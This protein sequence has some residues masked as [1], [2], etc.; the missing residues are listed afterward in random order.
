M[1][2]RWVDRY[3]WGAAAMSFG[4]VTKSFIWNINNCSV[5]RTN[6]QLLPPY[7]IR[8]VIVAVKAVHLNVLSV[9][10]FLWSYG[11]SPVIVPQSTR[12]KT[13]DFCP[14]VW[15]AHIVPQ[16]FCLTKVT[17]SLFS[18]SNRSLF[19]AANLALAGFPLTSALGESMHSRH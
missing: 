9:P 16:C 11:D 18:W 12:F 3:E 10:C 8:A 5:I 13:R 4:G 15:V 2:Y 1:S 17:F 6:Y 14:S 7:Q 19:S